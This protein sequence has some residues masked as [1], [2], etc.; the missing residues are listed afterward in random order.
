MFSVEF[1]LNYNA[2]AAQ[3]D[4]YVT[5]IGRGAQDA[6]LAPGMTQ[7]GSAYLRYTRRRF[8]AKQAGGWPPLAPSTV[9]DKKRRGT[10]AKGTL[11]DKGRM[12]KSLTPG[13][14]N[15]VLQVRGTAVAAGSSDPN[16][17]YHQHGTTRMPRRQVIDAPDAPAISEMD[18][19]TVAAVNKLLAV[20]FNKT[21]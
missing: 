6:T 13:N 11:I 7:A 1:N 12:V 19:E 10:F 17:P 8:Y 2:F 4:T 15:N 16:L 9:R 20:I 14:Q 18:R 21:P 5:R 3:V